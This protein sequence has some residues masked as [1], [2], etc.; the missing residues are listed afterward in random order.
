MNFPFSKPLEPTKDCLESVQEEFEES[1]G[2]Y[3]SDVTKNG[4][5][6][7]KNFE[8]LPNISDARRPLIIIGQLAV[9]IKPEPVFRLAKKLNV[10]VLSEQGLID[11]NF[12]I[13]GYEGFLHN[14]ENQANLK[15]D[16]ILRFGKE[17]AS[18]SLLK[19]IKK[20]RSV[21]HIHFSQIGYLS[22]I[23]GTTTEY[24]NWRESYFDPAEIVPVSHQW[25]DYWKQIEKIISIA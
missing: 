1:D 10:P 2:K 23:D 12:A 20:W 9:Q 24:A 13:Q 11:G 22:D 17:P 4:K 21:R 16:L 19:A 5:N 15:P 25:L 14:E 3:K 7:L 6:Y 18:S 8:S